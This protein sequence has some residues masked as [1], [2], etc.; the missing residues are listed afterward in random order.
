MGPLAVFSKYLNE[1]RILWNWK[2]LKNVSSHADY[3]SNF[4]HSNPELVTEELCYATHNKC[5]AIDIN[6][7]SQSEY[8]VLHWTFTILSTA[9][10]ICLADK[11]SH[12]WKTGHVARD[13]SISQVL[14][15]R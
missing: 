2:T 10:V 11:T 14:Q 9:T 1:M 4:R 12:V 5:Y 15:D 13:P 6:P 3:K 7:V 8:K